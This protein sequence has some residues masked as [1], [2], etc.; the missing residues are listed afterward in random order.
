M[1]IHFVTLIAGMFSVLLH[2]TML[3]EAMNP[4]RPWKAFIQ[5]MEQTSWEEY[6]VQFILLLPMLVA[7]SY[8]IIYK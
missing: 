8:S 7:I 5:W 6:T 2:P 3:S 1:R 4:A